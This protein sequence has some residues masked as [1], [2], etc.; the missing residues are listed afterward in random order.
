MNYIATFE[1]V[2]L[3]EYLRERLCTIDLEKTGMSMEDFEA[4]AKAEWEA[5]ELPTRSTQQSAGYD[6]HIPFDIAVSAN[7]VVVP[8]GVRCRMH[9]DWCLI[10]MPR[11][12]LGFKYGMALDNTLGLIDADY[13]NASNE[14]HIMAKIHTHNKIASLKQGDRFMQGVFL[15]YATASNGNAE[16][17][18]TGGFGSTGN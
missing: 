7:S 3:P 11:S 5:L 4:M 13:Y 1:K 8:T 9:P 17:Q 14:G 15:P 12:G 6:F 10:L 2:S 18:R 16:A